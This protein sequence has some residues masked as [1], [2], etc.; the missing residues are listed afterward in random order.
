MKPICH[1]GHPIWTRSPSNNI[2]SAKFVL[3]CYPR[4]SLRI[5]LRFPVRA[6][7][8]WVNLLRTAFRYE[9][10]PNQSGDVGSICIA[11]GSH[12]HVGNW[13]KRTSWGGGKR[14]AGIT[15]W[16]LSILSVLM[17]LVGLLPRI[18]TTVTCKFHLLAH[19]CSAASF[20]RWV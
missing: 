5:P 4:T 7:V 6:C 14:H 18:H 9:N 16:Q 12:W 11:S 15:L 1:Q 19:W 10:W 2:K 17:D 20:W 13:P 8:W 3:L